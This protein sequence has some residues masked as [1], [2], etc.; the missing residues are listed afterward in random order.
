[1]NAKE[2]ARQVG[3]LHH[4]RAILT[5]LIRALEKYAELQQ[6]PQASPHGRRCRGRQSAESA[7]SWRPFGR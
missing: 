2:V 6:L 4:R 5:N 7:R 1:M 3:I